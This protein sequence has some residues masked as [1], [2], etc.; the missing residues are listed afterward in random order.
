MR[1]QVSALTMEFLTWVA[2]GT[3]TYVEAMESWRTGCPRSSVWE[4]AVLAGLVRVEGEATFSECRVTL[5]P[6]GR[7]VL[8]RNARSRNDIS[9]PSPSLEQD[10]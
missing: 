3:R 2:S 9:S 1:E 8:D 4:D 7:D 10:C 5:T 6:R